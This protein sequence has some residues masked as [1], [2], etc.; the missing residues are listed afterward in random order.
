MER[1]STLDAGFYLVD[2]PDV[3][4]HMGSVAI[5]EGPVPRRAEIV[6]LFQ[7]RLPQIPR[8]RQVVLTTA[9]HL[10]R[11]AWTED[12]DFDIYH[13][14]RRTR[15]PRPGGDAEL[16]ELAGRIFAAP[17]DFGRPLWEAWLIDGLS[18]G[19]WAV[20]SKVHHC[21]VDGIG[22][23]DL[24]TVV[25]GPEP[26]S[27]AR[28]AESESGVA[29]AVATPIREM[30]GCAGSVLTQMP[31][32]RDV[33][34]YGQGLVR[35]AR[36]LAIPSVSSLN[37]PASPVRNWAWSSARLDDLRQIRTALGG[38]VND[39]LLT[40]VTGSLRGV[41]PESELEADTVVRALVPVSVRTVTEAGSVTN[42]LSAVLVNLP[43]AEPEPL[44]RLELIRAQTDELKRTHQAAGP[45]LITGMLGMVAS[46][47][48]A[49]ALR[50][51][52]RLPQPLVQAV[53]TNVPGPVTP[54]SALGH[55][56][57]AIY[58]YAPIGGNVRISVAMYSY[59][60]TVCFGITADDRAIA[61][62]AEL[63]LG[64]DREIGA[65]SRLT[66][67]AGADASAHAELLPPGIRRVGGSRPSPS[68]A[69][70]HAG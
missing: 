10:R 18:G 3:P 60:G 61:G 68:H 15:V 1:M 54:L 4:M 57:V 37:G 40:A 67:R 29:A 31:A 47:L 62:S 35:G 41:I 34:V 8:Y 6:R 69:V 13:H 25:F 11:P 12:P 56:L 33:A 50:R 32:L 30:A 43:V 24:M 17:L 52:F 21:V 45:E 65:L 2:H 38:T 55:P 70:R 44:R 14:I 22:G 51:A 19:R 64:I 48:L 16:R 53:V 28:C 26:D 59:A 42:R 39:V 66:G 49:A 46:P 20:L 58:P 5:F 63:T 36:R 23:S 27:P 9:H 7:A